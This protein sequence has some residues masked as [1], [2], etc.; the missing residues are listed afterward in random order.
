MTDPFNRGSAP[1][2]ARDPCPGAFEPGHAK[3][4]GREKGTRNLITPE[5]KMALLETARTSGCGCSIGK[6]TK[7]RFAVAIVPAKCAVLHIKERE[8]A[9]RHPAKVSR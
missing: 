5:R 1:G 6:Y 3:L 8:V 9:P 4:G 2:R 7:P